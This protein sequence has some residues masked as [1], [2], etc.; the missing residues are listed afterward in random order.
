MFK[1]KQISICYLNWANV[2]LRV[3]RSLRCQ[4]LYQPKP[5][6]T[7]CVHF[8]Y[9]WGWQPESILKKCSWK[10]VQ[11][12]IQLF[13][14]GIYIR[15]HPR[16]GQQENGDG[17]INPTFSSTLSH[18]S[19]SMGLV[20]DRCGACISFDEKSDVSCRCILF[21]MALA[22]ILQPRYLWTNFL[23]GKWGGRDLYFFLRM[24]ELGHSKATR[25]GY[26]P[27]LGPE[28]SINW[29][30]CLDEDLKVIKWPWVGS[31]PTPAIFMD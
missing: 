21:W 7:Q 13:C 9:H 17:Y 15:A 3:C 4:C 20:T 18:L 24:C 23:V 2:T 8:M 30:L 28:S 31:N 25:S 27:L 12:Q 16:V 5:G 10:K 22:R 14:A 19:K 1:Y 26:C 6:K 29:P 11:P